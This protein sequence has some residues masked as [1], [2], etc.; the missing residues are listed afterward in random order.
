M[1]ATD[2][3]RLAEKSRNETAAVR[4]MSPE[5]IAAI[6]LEANVM[7]ANLQRA[8]NSSNSLGGMEKSFGK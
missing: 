1:G 2:V 4:F 7:L 3:I 6:W 5:L 8:F